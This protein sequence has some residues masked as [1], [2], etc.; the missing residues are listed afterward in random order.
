MKKR[1]AKLHN[2]QDDKRRKAVAT[3]KL[4]DDGSEQE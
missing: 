1:E 3:E 4:N 2:K